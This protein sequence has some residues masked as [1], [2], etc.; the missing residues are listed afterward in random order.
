MGGQQN[1]YHIGMPKG[2]NTLEAHLTR[3]ATRQIIEDDGFVAENYLKSYIDFMKTPNS[4]PDTYA[5]T[6]HRM[7]FKNLQ[8]GKPANQCADNDHH[9]VD[10]IDAL[11]IA[12]PVIVHYREAERGL[13]NAKVMEAIKTMRNVKKV[14]K[15]AVVFSD[16]L[17]EVLQGGELKDELNKAAGKIGMGDLD[18]TVKRFGNE[19]PMVS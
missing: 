9:N 8:E 14:E 11:T 16:M 10:S 13:R 3:L 19:D 15:Y 6:A 5:A 7:F 12:V 18:K 1:H 17:T 4:H 2:E